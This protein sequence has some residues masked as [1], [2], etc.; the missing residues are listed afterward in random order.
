MF[1]Y[2]TYHIEILFFI[3]SQSPFGMKWLFLK[4]RDAEMSTLPDVGCGMLSFGDLSSLL[5]GALQRCKCKDLNIES[6]GIEG[7]LTQLAR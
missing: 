1:I 5:V 6:V 2:G 7:G 3:D 4:M